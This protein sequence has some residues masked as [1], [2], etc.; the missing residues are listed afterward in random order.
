MSTVST[1]HHLMHQKAKL[2]LVKKHLESMLLRWS[3]LL[4][5]VLVIPACAYTVFQW[6]RRVFFSNIRSWHTALFLAPYF[7]RALN[8]KQAFNLCWFGRKVLSLFFAGRRARSEVHGKA[9]FR[10]MGIC[11]NPFKEWAKLFHQRGHHHD[12]CLL[13]GTFAYVLSR[14]HVLRGERRF[15]YLALAKRCC[16]WLCFLE[17]G[18][19]CP[20]MRVR[21]L[22]CYVAHVLPYARYNVTGAAVL[23][24]AREVQATLLQRWNWLRKTIHIQILGRKLS[25][26]YVPTSY[27]S[28]VSSFTFLFF[29]DWFCSKHNRI[30]MM[31]P[32]LIVM[33][34]TCSIGWAELSSNTSIVASFFSLGLKPPRMAP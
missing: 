29:G 2:L 14:C 32:N 15:A 11:V 9:F 1:I 5:I 34:F 26:S 24:S 20:N 4:G 28:G 31:L 21:V 10:I 16:L 8:I 12:E 27:I 19:C 7:N 17:R 6:K 3:V 22:P 18:S 25:K 33:L 13:R 23:W 30:P